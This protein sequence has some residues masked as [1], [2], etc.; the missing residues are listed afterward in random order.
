M[1]SAID[2][3]F[4]AASAGVSFTHPPYRLHPL[5]PELCGHLWHLSRRPPSPGRRAG[6]TRDRLRAGR[7][8]ERGNRLEERLEE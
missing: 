6:H 2:S 4:C 8:A 3:V 7:G 5:R 1:V